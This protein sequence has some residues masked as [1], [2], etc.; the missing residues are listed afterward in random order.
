[1]GLTWQERKHHVLE[2]VISLCWCQQQGPMCTHSVLASSCER[3]NERMEEQ[4]QFLIPSLRNAPLTPSKM[5][6]FLSLGTAWTLTPELKATQG[7]TSVLAASAYYQWPSLQWTNDPSY[8][9]QVDKKKYLPTVL[10]RWPPR[11]HTIQVGKKAEFKFSLH[12]T[13]TDC[14][15]LLHGHFNPPLMLCWFLF[16]VEYSMLSPWVMLRIKEGRAVRIILHSS[17]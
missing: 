15:L 7:L 4:T 11:K 13:P 14:C 8:H 10:D 5:T 2:G 1:M 16:N 9:L 12:F 6:D 17:Y 3:G